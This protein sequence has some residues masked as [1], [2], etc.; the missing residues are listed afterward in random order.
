MAEPAHLAAPS[1]QLPRG[2][3]R[4]E[5]SVY[6][7]AVLKA[8]AG[9]GGLKGFRCRCAV[10]QGL[11]GTRGRVGSRAL[12]DL[13]GAPQLLRPP[14]EC[15]GVPAGA[16][17]SGMRAWHIGAIQEAGRGRG[18]GLRQSGFKAACAEGIPGFE[19][20]SSPGLVLSKQKMEGWATSLPTRRQRNRAGS[21]DSQSNLL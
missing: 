14:G 18:R 2:K 3:L 12:G 21:L 20:Q 15:E 5:R 8:R 9:P 10:D 13:R 6:V 16:S 17:Q 1:I 11:C 19:H 4:R 7:R